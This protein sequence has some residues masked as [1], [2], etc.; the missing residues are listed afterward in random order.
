M[1]ICVVMYVLAQVFVGW[2]VIDT[3]GRTPAVLTAL[4]GLVIVTNIFQWFAAPFLIWLRRADADE[5]V[6][7]VE[8]KEKQT[9]QE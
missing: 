6:N 1:E 5:T 2:R 9:R 7:L 4:V 8:R 3:F